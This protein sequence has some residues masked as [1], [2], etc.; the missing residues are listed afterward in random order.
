MIEPNDHNLPLGSGMYRVILK[1][2][3]A[4]GR[5]V[6]E[7]VRGERRS[8]VF[9]A[10][11]ELL[12]PGDPSLIEDVDA[13]VPEI[14]RIWERSGRR[15]YADIGF[16][17]DRWRVVN[18]FLRSAIRRSVLDFAVSTQKTF[19]DELL[20][21][22][23]STLDAIRDE[24]DKGRLQSGEAMPQ[25][26]KRIMQFFRDGNRARARRIAQTEATRAHHVARE[27]SARQSG[28]V[29]GWEWVATSASCP[30][31]D[32]I[33]S[34]SSSPDGRRRVKIGQPFA[35]VGSKSSYREV[36]FPPGHP[37]CRCTTRPILDAAYS[38]DPTPVYW[39]KPFVR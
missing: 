22:Y 18:E 38:K 27:Q 24:L 31:C 30:L 3:N 6:V 9:R 33:A 19:H 32:A 1:S 17:P 26:A 16:D 34:D 11:S 5:I 2:F 20:E 36:R 29:V 39:S 21:N 35:F 28:V 10:P 23:A 8:D 37:H 25:L 14:T 13:F 12:R 15:L 4:Q 7:R